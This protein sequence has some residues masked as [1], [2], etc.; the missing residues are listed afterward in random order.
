MPFMSKQFIH[1]A[2]SVCR[3]LAHQQVNA[4]CLESLNPKATVGLLEALTQILMLNSNTADETV[5]LLEAQTP[6]V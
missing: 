1:I 2:K 3:L 4:L 5:A 6:I